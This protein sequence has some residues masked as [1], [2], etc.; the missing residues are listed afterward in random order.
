MCTLTYFPKKTG[1]VF[2]HT[3]DE[4][5]G[6]PASETIQKGST[7]QGPLYFPQDL[8][9]SGT[10][11]ALGHNRAACILNGGSEVYQP[12]ANYAVSRG[13]IIPE[14]FAHK[15]VGEF[16]QEHDFNPYEPFTLIIREGEQLFQ[17]IHNPT[18]NQLIEHNAEEVNI[19]S[20]TKLYRSEIR[21]RRKEQFFQWLIENPQPTAADLKNFHLGGEDKLENSGFRIKV[22]GIIETVSLTQIE[23]SASA[24]S[25]FYQRLPGMESDFMQV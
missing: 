11:M 19:W 9:A 12:Q 6:R 8:K 17:L 14:L 25:I 23:V 22:E 10:W 13:N 24:S 2:T 7:T 5:P 3:R 4:S 20:S 15:S 16:Y 1:F 21:Q 18:Q